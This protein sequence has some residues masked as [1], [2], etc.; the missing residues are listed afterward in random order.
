LGILPIITFISKFP[1]L[2]GKFLK[3]AVYFFY[4]NVLFEFAGLKLGN[5]VFPG[6][7]YIGTINFFGNTVPYEEIIA[8]WMLIAVG[9]LTYY[10]FFDDDRK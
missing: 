2:L 3:T 8:W 5:W 1:R 4:L 7:N 10:E 6:Q 9:I